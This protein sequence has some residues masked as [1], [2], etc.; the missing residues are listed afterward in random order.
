MSAG[1]RGIGV[2]VADRPARAGP[3]HRGPAAQLWSLGKIAGLAAAARLATREHELARRLSR[4]DRLRPRPA[5]GGRA[6]AVRGLL[7]LS[8]EGDLSAARPRA[9]CR[10]EI[11][12]ALGELRDALQRPLATTSRATRT[13]CGT[14]SAGCGAPTR[15]STSRSSTAATS[16]FRARLQPVAQSVLREAVRNAVKHADPTLHRGAAA[17]TPTAPSCSRSSTTASAPTAAPTPRRAWACASPPSRRSSP[18][19]S[20]T[21]ARSATTAGASG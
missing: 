8:G 18:A 14:S 3:A 4:A 1:G 20:S 10:E 2:I 7:A 13:T 17:P 5:R 21:S 6:A 11:Q 16:P 19:G 12:A 9:R 15:R